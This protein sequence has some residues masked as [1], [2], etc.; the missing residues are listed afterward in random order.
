MICISFTLW[1]TWKLDYGP[2]IYRHKVPDKL[3]E[4]YSDLF[5]P[6][7]SSKGINEIRFGAKHS[8]VSQLVPVSL[9]SGTGGSENWLTSNLLTGPVLIIAETTRNLTIYWDI[10]EDMLFQDSL[11]MLKQASVNI[12]VEYDDITAVQ[13]TYEQ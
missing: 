6:Y 13:Q 1:W 7:L 10:P 11:E 2:L 9:N 3:A 4:A 5:I 12:F 8:H